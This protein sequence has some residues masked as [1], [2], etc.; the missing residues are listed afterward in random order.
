MKISEL[1]ETL[2]EQMEQHGDADVF[3]ND[4]EPF[5]A[6]Q[7]EMVKEADMYDPEHFGP[8]YLFLGLW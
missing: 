8:Q 6:D 3:I 1:I 2:T 5:N 7:I 4:M